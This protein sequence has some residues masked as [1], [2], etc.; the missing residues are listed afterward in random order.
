VLAEK[1]YTTVI[2]CPISTYFTN[3]STL[4]LPL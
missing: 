3:L 4:F 2:Y 1:V